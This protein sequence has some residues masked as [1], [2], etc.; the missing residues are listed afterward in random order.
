MIQTL[1]NAAFWPLS[2]AAVAYKSLIKACSHE[3]RLAFAKPWASEPR[4]APQPRPVPSPAT[5][6][7]PGWWQSPVGAAQTHPAPRGP[8][9]GRRSLCAVLRSEAL[10]SCQ[11]PRCEFAARGFSCLQPRESASA[12]NRERSLKVIRKAF[13]KGKMPFEKAGLELAGWE[14]AAAGS[15]GHPE[16]PHGC[17]WSRITGGAE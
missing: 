7:R 15:A 9:G 12:K 11:Q 1:F 6:V 4:C 5:P 16:L 10:N 14:G 2:R 3:T 8:R 17:R 13:L